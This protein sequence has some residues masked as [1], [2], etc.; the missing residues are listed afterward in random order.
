MPG[1]GWWITPGGGIDPGESDVDAAVRELEE[2]TGIRVEPR[3]LVGPILVRRVVHGYTDV[4]IDQGDVFFACWVP[5]FEVS[6]AGYT[7]E[8]RLT[9]T[10][11]RWWTRAELA[12]TGE[13]VWPVDLVDVW[14][15]ADGRRA[16]LSRGDAPAPPLVG[17]TVE[18]S[19]VP[20]GL[21]PKGLRPDVGTPGG[22]V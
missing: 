5:A 6:D 21:A 12:A 19:T 11:S 1:R 2:E 10:A 16:A 9:M 22:V 20:A 14:L 4:V 15:G 18:E 7:E 8:E 13:E 3:E 17:P